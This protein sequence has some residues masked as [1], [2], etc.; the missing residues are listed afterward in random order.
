[1]HNHLHAISLI[2]IQ[3]KRCAHLNLTSCVVSQILYILSISTNISLQNDAH[4]AL[5]QPFDVL[6][7]ASRLCGG[8]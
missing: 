1:M 6:A 5:L 3:S 8:G 7:A 4:D 2:Y